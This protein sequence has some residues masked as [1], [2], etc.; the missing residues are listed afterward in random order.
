MHVVSTLFKLTILN[1]EKHYEIQIRI[2][3]PE[4]HKELIKDMNYLG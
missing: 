2:Q 4:N 3:N 1:K